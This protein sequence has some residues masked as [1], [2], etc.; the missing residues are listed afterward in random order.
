M[1]CDMVY[2]SFTHAELLDPLPLQLHDSYFKMWQRL[3]N[4]NGQSV[5]KAPL[6]DK[7]QMIILWFWISRVP[8]VLHKW[9]IWS[10]SWNSTSFSSWWKS[11]FLSCTIRIEDKSKFYKLVRRLEIRRV[12][13]HQDIVN[14]F[15]VFPWKIIVL[16]QTCVVLNMSV[17]QGD[18]CLWE[19]KMRKIGY[20]FVSRAKT[21]AS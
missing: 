21:A 12:C 19:N 7:L 16:D 17:F 10:K 3:R 14:A 9:F 5:V 20:L 18:L 11:V 13:H 15:A 1:I 4:L 8:E 6:E 2:S